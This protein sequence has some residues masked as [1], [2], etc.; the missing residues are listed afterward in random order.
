MTKQ[1]SQ[2]CTAAPC[3]WHWTASEAKSWV[4]ASWLLCPSFNT[5]D[6]IESTV[7]HGV[8]GAQQ[9]FNHLDDWI[10]WSSTSSHYKFIMN[11]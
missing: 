9:M 7:S 8:N 1:N 10:L 2:G 4:L 5:Q 3:E 11:I 6:I